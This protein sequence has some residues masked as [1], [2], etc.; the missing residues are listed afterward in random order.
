MC[1][2]SGIQRS[3]ENPPTAALDKSMFESP[4][5]F[6]STKKQGGKEFM[7]THL[8]IESSKSGKTT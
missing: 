6:V 5:A 2:H 4:K 1:A 7:S 8:F 3:S